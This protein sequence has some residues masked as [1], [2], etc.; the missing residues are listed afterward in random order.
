MA[1]MWTLWRFHSNNLYDKFEKKKLT[2]KTQYIAFIVYMYMIISL[3]D[4]LNSGGGSGVWY[5]DTFFH[6]NFQISLSS[7]AL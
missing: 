1:L 7:V 5:I 3:I 4:S 2:I 6:F